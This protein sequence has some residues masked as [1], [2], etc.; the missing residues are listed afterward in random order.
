ML[1]KILGILESHNG[2]KK[3]VFQRKIL[4]VEE[5][6]RDRR[7]F[8]RIVDRMGHKALLAENAE[9]GLEIAQT[10]KPDLI[11]LNCQLP[12]LSGTQMCK[13]LKEQ[14]TTKNIPVLFLA[15]NDTAKDFFEC[16]ELDAENFLAKPID[17]KVL[18]SQIEISLKIP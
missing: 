17:P 8:S 2:L 13:K 11:L 9:K 14:P 12:G 4:I 18:M 1:K 16:F 10:E 6:D 7:T 5:N 3:D 15:E